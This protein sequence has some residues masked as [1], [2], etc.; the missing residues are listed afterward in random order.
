CWNSVR[1]PAMRNGDG[2]TAT[3]RLVTGPLGVRTAARTHSRS[4]VSAGTSTPLPGSVIVSCGRPAL[5]LAN[6]LI[7]HGGV[8]TS[9][10]SAMSSPWTG[11][12]VA[13]A[14]PPGGGALHGTAA[15]S[16]PGP[17]TLRILSSK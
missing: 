6:A 8:L 14:A 13:V 1:P 15:V 11:S 16:G 7:V 17:D 10:L 4:A 9:P 2:P 12:L 3:L 5:G